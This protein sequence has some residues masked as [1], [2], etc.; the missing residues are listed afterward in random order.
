MKEIFVEGQSRNSDEQLYE[1]IK[2]KK[3]LDAHYGKKDPELDLLVRGIAKR[4][5]ERRRIEARVEEARRKVSHMQEVREIDEAI[6][7]IEASDL[8]D[9]NLTNPGDVRRGESYIDAIKRLKRKKEQLEDD[10]II[11]EAYGPSFSYF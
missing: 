5:N 8:K 4:E 1:F 6:E 11:E 2:A 7:R 3:V 10:R 9:D